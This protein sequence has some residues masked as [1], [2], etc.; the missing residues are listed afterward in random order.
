MSHFNKNT[1][2]EKNLAGGAAYAESDKMQLV[3]ILLTSFGDD[4][5]YQS[6]KGVEKELE[7]LI[8]EVDPEF[9][10]KAAIYA[11]TVFG[12]RTIT[13]I[14]ASIL[15]GKLQGEKAR[16]FFR[17]VV[18]RPDDITEILACHI[19]GRGQKVSNAMKRGLGD[20]LGRFDEYQLAKYRAEGKRMK[21][22]DA[23]NICHPKFTPTA[24]EAVGK[25]VRDELR[26]ADTWE[27]RLSA[28]GGDTEAKKKVWSELLTEH[29]LGYF[30]LLRN[31]RNISSLSDEEL[32][33]MACSQLVNPEAIRKSLVLPFR[34]ATAFKN[35]NA[36][37]GMVKK[38][39]SDA[40]DIALGNMPRFEGRSLVALDVSGSMSCVATIAAMFAA[41]IIK[42]N[43]AD[44][45]IFSDNASYRYVNPA[46]SLLTIM[47][48]LRFADGGTNFVDIFRVAQK[49]YDRIFLL[50]DMQAW[51]ASG[52]VKNPSAAFNEYRRKYSPE[53]KVYSFD[54]A[55]YGTM[56]LPERDV[57][58]VAGFSDKI[59]DVLKDF[60]TDPRAL[61]T[62]IEAL[63]L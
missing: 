48:Q 26:S 14:A 62:R 57:Y 41:A 16:R 63:E 60:D 37:E 58:A 28:V 10:A 34:F 2:Q 46:D 13:H 20:A 47:D 9:C 53:C 32:T 50:S 55:G 8:G 61:I 30:A 27:A 35:I 7:K 33:R 23:V 43:D 1:Q 36:E 31:L 18:R 19:D 12:M 15:A 56:Q 21:L 5:Y 38:A 24:G 44:L 59:F 22:V 17:E 3:S 45:I 52:W 39:I 11:R 49:K 4:K 54:L 42:T 6:H 29:R 40:A 51:K 25:L